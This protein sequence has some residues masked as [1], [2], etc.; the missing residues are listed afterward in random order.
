MIGLK[1][2]EFIPHVIAQLSMIGRA[3]PLPAGAVRDRALRNHRK[4]MTAEFTTRKEHLDGIFSFAKEFATKYLRSSEEHPP[5]SLLDLNMNACLEKTRRE[6]G[7]LAWAR[8]ALYADDP[9]FVQPDRPDGVLLQEFTDLV[10][11]GKVVH[12]ALA[13]TSDP[14]FKLRSHVA[15]IEERGLKARIV[16][17]SQASVLV[18]G[19][20]ARQRLIRGIKRIPECRGA[21]TGTSEADLINR[22]GGCSGEVISSDLRAASDLHPRDLARSLVE[23]LIASNKFSEAEARGMLL[24]SADHELSY[25]DHDEVVRQKRGLLMG[26]PT[27]WIFLSLIHLYWWR[28]AQES[29]PPTHP[30]LKARA[31][32]CGDDL[33]AVAPPIL[34]DEY[35]RNMRACGGELSAGKHCRSTYRGVFLEMLVE[36][37]SERSWR[38]P[39]EV[40]HRVPLRRNGVSKLVWKRERRL[41]PYQGK[42]KRWNTIP[43]KGFFDAGPSHPSRKL[44]SSLPDWVMA[45]EVSEALRVDGFPAPLVHVL[46]RVAFPRAIQSLRDHRIPP[47]LPRFLGGG[48]LVPLGGEETK[49]S[50]LASRGFR[51][52]L[53]SLLTDESCDRDPKVLARI[54]LAT[55]ERVISWASQAVDELLEHTNHALGEVPPEQ[56]GPWFDC[57]TDFRETCLSRVNRRLHLAMELPVSKVR[58]SSVSK[59]LASKL[60]KLSSKW[61]SCQPWSKSIAATR[62]LYNQLVEQARVWLPPSEDPTRPGTFGVSFWK[63]SQPTS[64]LRRLV[65]DAMALPL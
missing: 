24:C 43:L 18:L 25:D 34:L 45:G 35:E 31:V 46:V 19:H 15:V 60:N 2:E 20:L 62:S 33:L 11:D 49:I 6:G 14:N 26:L 54:W 30:G 63:D 52:A 59:T 41:C 53:S 23:G 51:K 48:G 17:K 42:P 4:D 7:Q 36:F 44:P 13:E 1:C 16:T 21:L 50:R 56:G 3:L 22:L 37:H 5:F 9:T 8:E 29:I 39:V 57:G 27:T 55:K 40:L 32:I 47:Y 28:R 38:F 64:Q 58:L 12:R 61:Q 10:G 65:I